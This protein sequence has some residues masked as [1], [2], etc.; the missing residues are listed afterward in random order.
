[1]NRPD[2]LRPRKNSEVILDEQASQQTN[3]LLETVDPQQDRDFILNFAMPYFLD[4]FRD[5]SSRN[6]K[7]KNFINK[8]ILQEV[9]NDSR[10][11]TVYL[12]LLPSWNNL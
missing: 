6:S 11:K 12:V 10:N 8:H 9:S 5:L 3:L 7:D 1:M 2:F 4:L